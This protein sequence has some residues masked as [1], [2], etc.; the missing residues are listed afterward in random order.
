M[1]AD[2]EDEESRTSGWSTF[3]CKGDGTATPEK[4]DE[5]VLYT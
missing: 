1:F 5:Y 3:L 4:P 2:V